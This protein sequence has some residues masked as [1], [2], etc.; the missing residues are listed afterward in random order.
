M[1]FQ[2]VAM[3]G[4]GGAF[5]KITD[6]AQGEAYSINSFYLSDT[7]YGPRLCV[8]MENGDRAIL[9]KRFA[10]MASDIEKVEILNSK[11]FQMIFKGINISKKNMVMLDFI[12]Y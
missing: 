8:V 5:I 12:E 7:R 2:R 3:H 9:P 4:N 10:D 11:R 6:L 1:D